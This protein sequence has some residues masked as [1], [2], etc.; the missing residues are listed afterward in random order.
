MGA[1]LILAAR[2]PEKLSKLKIELEHNYTSTVTNIKFDA[3][4]FKSHES[5]YSNLSNKPDLVIC[6]FGFLGNQK[7]A[8]I[9]FSESKTIIETNFLG[10]ISI[11]N[12]IANEFEKN[13]AGVIVGISSVAGD[14]GREKN[15][16][17]EVLKQDLQR[18]YQG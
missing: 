17:T 11:L 14:R 13:N 12:I 7:K 10:A 8:E 6:V 18:T 2:E 4:D 1:N 5:F 9:K 3:L 16:Y 15:T